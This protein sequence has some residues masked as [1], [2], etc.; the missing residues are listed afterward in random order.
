MVTNLVEKSVDKCYDYTGQLKN[1]MA[2]LDYN[3]YYKVSS[4]GL[5]KITKIT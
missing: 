1:D 3:T 5:T 2:S 4:D